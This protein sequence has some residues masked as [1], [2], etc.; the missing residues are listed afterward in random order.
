[1]L[2]I[3]QSIKSMQSRHVFDSSHAFFHGN[4]HGLCH[5]EYGRRCG[6]I[7]TRGCGTGGA[8]SCRGGQCSL[9]SSDWLV[10]EPCGQ[11]LA[12]LLDHKFRIGRGQVQEM[13]DEIAV[14]EIA[15]R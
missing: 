8:C 1:M 6:G 14:N 5:V 11:V 7:Y 9:V 13:L 12:E 4:A 15:L 3:N 2:L 10:V